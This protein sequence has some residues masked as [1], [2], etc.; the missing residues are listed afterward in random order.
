MRLPFEDLGTFKTLLKRFFS[1][2]PWTPEDAAALDAVVRPHLPAGWWEHQLD[3]I[4]MSHGVIDDRYELWVT[5]GDTAAPSVFD[6]TFSGPVLPEATPHPQKV[7]FTI[8]G[9]PSPGIWYQRD[10]PGSDP[11]VQ[12]IFDEPDVTDVMVAGDFV[13]IGLDRSSSWQDRLDPILDLVT[14]VFGEAPSGGAVAPLRTRDEL[15]TEGRRTG[16]DTDRPVSP[17]GTTSLHLLDPDA[18]DDRGLLLDALIDTDARR[19]RTAVAILAESADGALRRRALDTGAA[20]RSRIVRRAAVD[21]AA[22][23]GDES[24]RDLFVGVLDDVDAWVRWKAVRSLGELGVDPSRG[25]VAALADDPDF[26]VRFE[27]ARVLRNQ[28]EPI[29]TVPS[30]PDTE[31]PGGTTR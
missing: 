22:D 28:T 20:D 16:G 26:Q 18:P 13:T 12:R 11:R 29:G 8:G 5:G 2:E 14:G 31:L 1:S 4:T 21:A 30:G 25:A 19:R 7:K 17:G 9:E 3:D 6:R 27:V 24:L 10:N 23:L 15:I